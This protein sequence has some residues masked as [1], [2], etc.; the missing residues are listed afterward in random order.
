MQQRV[1]ALITQRKKQLDIAH[2][3]SGRDREQRAQC[4]NIRRNAT[5]ICARDLASHPRA[6]DSM[7]VLRPVGLYKSTKRLLRAAAH[8]AM[9]PTTGMIDVDVKPL[10][11]FEL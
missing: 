10:D 8:K 9:V 4:A 11:A 3:D 5:R 7:P 1:Y 6:P 2:T